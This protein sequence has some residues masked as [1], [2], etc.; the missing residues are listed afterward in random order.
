MGWSAFRPQGP[1]VAIAVTTSA[2]TAVQAPGYSGEPIANNYLF[3]NTTTQPVQ[4]GYGP[5][6]LSATAVIPTPGA[7]NNSFWLGPNTSQVLTFGPATW[8]S[9]I[10]STG[11]STVLVTPGD[12]L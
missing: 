7:A 9:T 4:V 5:N 8:F 3:S 6:A 10:A 12:G 1:T 2:S 11:S